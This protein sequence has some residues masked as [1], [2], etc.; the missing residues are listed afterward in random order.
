M[1][2]I[3]EAAR[4]LRIGRSAAYKLAREYLATNGASGIPTVRIGGQR[5]VP[6]HRL[7]EDLGGPITWPIPD[8]PADD[9]TT[10]TSEPV[11][12]AE[13]IPLA[14]PR[15]TRRNGSQLALGLD[16]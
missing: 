1:L 5:R 2:T 6:R 12:L 16:D 7:E 9:P 10:G 11:R 15:A 14:R 4:I 8:A 3:E 13:T